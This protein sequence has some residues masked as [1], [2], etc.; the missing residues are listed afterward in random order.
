MIVQN[1][2]HSFSSTKRTVVTIGTFD[3]VHI[4]HKKIL[5][6]VVQVAQEKNLASVV[7]T[8]W[9]H[10]RNVLKPK[11]DSIPLLFS[12]DEKLK[13]FEALQI[14]HVVVIPFD[15][16]IAGQS[17][18][19][20][21]K[22]VLVESL[23][24]QYLII[25]YDHHFGHNR[26]G[27]LGFL[28]QHA[29]DFDFEVEEIAAQDIDAI[30]VSSSKIRAALI[31]GN[32]DLANAYIGSPYQLEA[33]VVRGAQIGRSLGY[34]TANLKV[35]EPMKLLPA[36][37]VYAVQAIYRNKAYPAM[38]NIGTKPTFGAK[39]LTLEVHMIGFNKDIYDQELQILFYKRLRDEVHFENLDALKTQLQIDRQQT[40]LYF[41]A[42]NKI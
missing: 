14:D 18:M 38:M 22:S 27:N 17:A 39:E 1:A 21:T 24:T 6:R 11:E 10:P 15:L 30:S 13:A 19:E 33:F 23:H 32:I 37:G 20:F 25:G 40:E 4:G 36:S 12:L 34:P 2:L 42:T 26:E 8:F 9:P 7:L 29:P 35:K 16:S 41:N 5:H 31:E 28:K 3:G